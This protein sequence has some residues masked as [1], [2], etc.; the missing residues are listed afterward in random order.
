MGVTMNFELGEVLSRAWQITWKHKVLWI[1]GI[2]MGFFV[3]IMFPLM[4]SP[5][6]LPVLMQ[7]S[8][9][10]LKP[11]VGIMIGLIIF[12]LLFMLALY[13]ISVLAQ[14]SLTLGVLNANKDNREN[15]SAMDLVKRSF[16]FFWRALGLMLLYAVGIGLISFILQAILFLLTILTLGLAALCMMPLTLLMY[17]LLFGSIV[18]MEQAM[19]GIV[20]DNMTI[21]DAVRQ[22]WSL[23]RDNL[24]SF[25][26]I[27]LVVYFGLGLVT[28]AL[29]MP[30]MIPLFMVPFSFVEHQTNWPILSISILWTLAFIPVFA[31]ISG[32]SMIFTK[33]TWVLTYLRFTRSPK[34]RPLAGTVEATS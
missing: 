32:F 33:S 5:I 7:N 9:T 17:P 23:L 13:P 20:V 8:K 15:L 29:M 14:T 21:A 30:M 4:F 19:N 26:L 16:P 28:G 22:G 2:L 25:T 18:W 6:L 12:L 10:D 24:P 34:L 27:A 31:F 1:I 11:L 3:S